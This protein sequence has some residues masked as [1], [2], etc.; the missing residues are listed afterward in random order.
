MNK[1]YICGN[2]KLDGAVDVQGSKNAALPIIAASLL[3]H[4]E[5]VLTN[6]PDLKDVKAALEIIDRLGGKTAYQEHTAIIKAENI[7]RSDISDDLMASMRSSVLFLGPIISRTKKA[8][9]SYPGGCSI[10]LRPIDLHLKAFK[11]LGVLVEETGGH[12]Y[13]STEKIKSG[14]VN[15]IFPSVG[16]TENIMMLAA[17]SNA[18]VIIANAAREPEIL[19]LQNFLNKMGAKISGAGSETIRIIGVEKLNKVQYNIMAD[20]IFAATVFCAAAACGGDVVVKGVVPE[21]L[22]L[23]LS[24]LSGAGAEVTSG[25]DF[26]RIKCDKRISGLG[27]VMTSPYPGFPTDAQAIFMSSLLCAEGT[28]VFVENIF[29]SRYKHVPELI[30]MGADI[31]VDGRLAVVSG[32]NFIQGAPVEA[33]DLRGGAALVVAGLSAIGDTVV[34]GLNHIDRGYE[35]IEDTFAHL[36]ATIKRLE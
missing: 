12:I 25:K 5:C 21:Q 29:E 2:K 32:C 20:R 34:T 10:G 26:V 1:I 24:M 35:K 17:V 11:Q 23:M 4:Q 33:M 31:I 16:A 30:K 18:E 36:G 3:N 28:T 19:D 6:C 13:C 8:V 14:K 9:I 27:K 15:L 7:H 22:E